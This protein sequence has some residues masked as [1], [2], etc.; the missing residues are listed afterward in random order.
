MTTQE[1]TQAVLTVPDRPAVPGLIF[2]GFRGSDDYPAMAAVIMGSQE[3]DGSE[4]VT[5]VEDIARNYDHLVNC[6]PAR[7]MI[8]AEVDQEVVGYGRVTWEK[9]LDGSHSYFQFAFLL[10]DWR[11]KGIRRAM[12]A[13]NE[14]RLRTIAAK[15]DA[16]NRFFEAW[17]SQGETHWAALLENLDYRPARHSFSMVRPNLDD[18][19]D[20]PLPAG[21]EVRP[22]KPEQYRLVWEAA[23]EAFRDHWG[24]GEWHDEYYESWLKEPV[25]M[26]HMWQVAWDGDEVAGMVLNFIDEAENEAFDR[27]RGYTETIC[28]RRPYRR[29]GLARALIARS[30][31]VLKA[32][33]MEEA[34]LG[35]DAEN[36]SGA[37]RLYKF[38]GFQEVRRHTNYRKA[39]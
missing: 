30:F 19:P 25:F 3:T 28:V 33:G 7:D 8:F 22:V 20:L 1:M 2:R 21:L 38:M 37:L 16:G 27:L 23:A 35:V 29:L 4:H 12:V 11:G 9:L 6:D 10:P 32:A 36:I 14:R 18:I 5:T 39:F 34:A 24:A 31:H 17:A 26:P 13:R 15:H